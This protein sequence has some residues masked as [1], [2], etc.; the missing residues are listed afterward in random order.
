MIESYTD[1]HFTYELGVCGDYM[2][3]STDSTRGIMDD[4]IQME[5]RSD[6]FC[7]SSVF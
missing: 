3:A 7:R 4:I 1:P 5:V 2:L 6:A